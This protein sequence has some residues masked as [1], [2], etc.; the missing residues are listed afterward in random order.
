[1]SEASISNVQNWLKTILVSP[2]HVP[3]KISRAEDSW[4]LKAQELVKG[5]ENVS[6][7]T[8][9]GIYAMGYMLRLLECMQADLP[10][11]YAFWGPSL[12]DLFGKAY[13]LQH[14][15]QSYS[16]YDLTAG[17]ADFLDRTRPPDE[18]IDR[19][20]SVQ[21]AIPAELVRME[22][23]RLAAILSK[24]T[25]GIETVSSLGFFSFFSGEQTSFQAH[26]A[27]QLLVQKMPLV[28]LYRQLM[29]D[30]EPTIPDFQTTYIAVTRLH[31][32][33]R[34]H[35][36]SEQQFHFLSYLQSRDQPTD[37]QEAIHY[38]AL[39]TSQDKADLL[40]TICLWLPNAI[41]MGLLVEAGLLSPT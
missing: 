32:R 31:F 30:E 2:G 9:I 3:E 34:F 11:L 37:L 38:T 12:F 6:R 33:I 7:E 20:N 35:E 4:K 10:S 28:D 1:M 5:D 21:Y 19:E 26:P 23:A 29:Q 18:L 25:E 40:S 8:R 36:I 39:Q 15:S 22:R 14:P 27:L 16:L 24:G 17:F 13:I 41:D